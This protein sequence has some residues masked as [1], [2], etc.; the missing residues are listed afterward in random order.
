L[1]FKRLLEV[2]RLQANVEFMHV[3][4]DAARL[5]FLGGNVV[6]IRVIFASV[7]RNALDEDFVNDVDLINSIVSW[8]L[9]IK[10]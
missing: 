2:V 4:S 1:L 9:V 8:R 6:A 7:G 10:L 5:K 3:P